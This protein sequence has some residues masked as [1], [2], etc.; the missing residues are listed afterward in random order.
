MKFKIT[1]TKRDNDFYKDYPFLKEKIKRVNN[2]LSFSKTYCDYYIELKSLEDLVEIANKCS[3][4]GADGLIINAD[5]TPEIEI[6][7]YWRE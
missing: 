7:D 5:E 1:S 3:E 2:P 4:R 6:Y